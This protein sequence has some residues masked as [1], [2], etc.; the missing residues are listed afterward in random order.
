MDWCPGGGWYPAGPPG[1][2]DCCIGGGVGWVG[3][4]SF[5]LCRTRKSTPNPIR[6]ITATP[7]TTPPAMA[8]ALAAAPPP[9]PPPPPPSLAAEVVLEELDEELDVEADRADERLVR[10]SDVESGRGRA[11]KLLAS[12]SPHNVVKASW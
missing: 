10:S 11:T 5:L 9:P 8:P 7:P 2:G 1:A 4:G 12:V 3:A 6:P